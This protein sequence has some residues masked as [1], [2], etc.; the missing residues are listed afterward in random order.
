MI[1]SFSIRYKSSFDL[2][3]LEIKAAGNPTEHILI[4]VFSGVLEQSRILTLI[5]EIQ[6]RLP[7]VSIVGTSTGGEIVDGQS[8]EEEIV[9]NT[10][11]F[12]HTRVTTA[13][14][15]QND[16]LSAAGKE[17]G[18]GLKNDETRVAIVFGCGLKEKNHQ[19]SGATE[20]N[21]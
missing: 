10:T 4:Q 3:E 13:I 20:C 11:I 21:S 15:F 7:G 6:Q 19:G 18:L 2:E 9:I 1:S 17:I 14:T 8:L 16:D 5:D 12:E